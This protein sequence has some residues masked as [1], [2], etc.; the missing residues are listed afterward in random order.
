[1]ALVALAGVTA[2]P[3]LAR[4][5]LHEAAE[6][7]AEAWRGTGATVA[8]DRTRFL[9]DE[10]DDERPVVIELPE[11]PPGACTTVVL[12]GARGLGFHVRLPDVGPEEGPR[13]VPSVAGVVSIERCGADAP[14]RLVVATDSGRG[15]IET[16][17]GRS[18]KPLPALRTV[19]PERSGGPL[20]PASE[21]GP[22]PAL[23]SPEKRADI[24]EVR[25]K[26][27]GATIGERLTWQAERDGTGRESVT[28]EAGCHTLQL[29]ALDPRTGH[30]AMRG[31]L[32]LDAEMREQADERLLARDRTDAPDASL[33]ACFG[34]ST[35][36]RI[37]YTGSP[38]G[39]T[40]LVA[41]SAW[42]LPERLPSLWGAEARGRMAHVLQARHVVSLPRE[43]AMLAQGGSGT[44]PLPLSL[45]PGA[46]YLALVTPVREMA[47]AIGMHVRVGAT[48]ASDDRGIETDGAAVAFC[49][50]G[51]THALAEVQARGTALLGWGFALYRVQSGVWRDEH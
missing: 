10:S 38:P 12:L 18:A 27:D 21:A 41:H 9:S 30:P 44:T 20:M 25:G 32:D 13:R 14:R 36:V 45:E 35:A 26:R 22:L 49:A 42:A 8:V 31:K 50:A 33:S 16:V 24:A 43:P 34:E 29:F 6:R 51:Q 1:M 2:W 23:P 40:V 19:L 11:L 39:A 7:V 37:V 17:V 4:A 46:C 28:L 47:R 5:E 3:R 48:D 15:A